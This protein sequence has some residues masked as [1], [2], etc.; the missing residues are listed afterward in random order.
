MILCGMCQI[1]LLTAKNPLY[2][3]VCHVISI[4]QLNQWVILNIIN[5]GKPSYIILAYCTVQEVHYKN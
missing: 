1:H 4:F 2:I 5:G 3:R